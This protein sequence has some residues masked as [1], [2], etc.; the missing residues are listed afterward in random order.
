MFR[1]TVRRTSRRSSTLPRHAASSHH[2][3]GAPVTTGSAASEVSPAVSR[4]NRSLAFVQMLASG[5][6]VT[7][8]QLE[9]PHQPGRA[10]PGAGEPRDRLRVLAELVWQHG[11]LYYV[12]SAGLNGPFL[13]YRWN[14]VTAAVAQITALSGASFPAI[15]VGRTAGDGGMHVCPQ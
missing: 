9:G 3:D 14:R 1:R 5:F 8:V 10:P 11:Y 6:S 2:D 13:V 15:S 7:R 4:D 12:W